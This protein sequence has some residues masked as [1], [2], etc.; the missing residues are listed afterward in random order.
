KELLIVVAATL[1]LFQ[2]HQILLREQDAL[3]Q[4]MECDQ[5]GKQVRH[6]KRN[7]SSNAQIRLELNAL[8]PCLLQLQAFLN[9]LGDKYASMTARPDCTLP[10]VKSDMLATCFESLEDR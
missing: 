7:Q 2:N 5:L 10:D 3:G 1:Q 6:T 9:Q 4:A 8:L